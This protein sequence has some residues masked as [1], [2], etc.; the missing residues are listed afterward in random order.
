MAGSSAARISASGAMRLMRPVRTLPGPTSTNVVTPAAAMR[1]TARDPVD[2]GGQVLDELGPGGLGGRDRAGVGVGEQR[3]GRVAE[4]DRRRARRASPRRPRP[5][6]ASGRRPRPAG[7]SRAWRRASLASSAPASIAG[8]SPET[9]TWPGRVAV[10]DDERCRAPRRR[11]DELREPGVVE[12]DD[13]GHRAVAARAGRLH[14]PA[15]LADEADA[16]VE[17]DDARPRRAP[18]TGPSSG[19]RRR[20]APAPATPAAAQRSRSAA[21]IAIEAARSAGWAFSVRSS[22]SAGPSQASALIGS[23]RAASAAAKT[24][25][26]AG[27]RVGEGAAH[28]DRLGAL[29]GEDEGKR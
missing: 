26:A 25:A 3:D 19:R 18:S 20:R 10:G 12:A 16:V 28:P 13:R 27:E 2:A 22:A 15:A 14:Q 17:R 5:S 24:A 23:P 9:T 8:R 29:A 21:R 7:R 6:A 11:C 1:S 4:R